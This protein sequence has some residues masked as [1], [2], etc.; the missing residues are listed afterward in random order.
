MQ[1]ALAVEPLKILSDRYLRSREPLGKFSHQ[2]PAVTVRQ[3]ENLTASFL[4]QMVV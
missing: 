2:N 4:C 3:I 1:Q